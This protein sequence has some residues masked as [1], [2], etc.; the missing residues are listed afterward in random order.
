MEQNNNRKKKSKYVHLVVKNNGKEYGILKLN[1][2]V[3]KKVLT[4]AVAGVMIVSAG[5]FVKNE[6]EEN[7][8]ERE[9]EYWESVLEDY[10]PYEQTFEVPYTVQAGDTLDG[11]IATYEDD[12][13]ERYSIRDDIARENNLSS[14]SNIKAGQELT[15]TG[16]EAEDLAQFGYTVDYSLFDPMVKV[17]DMQ[18]FLSNQLHGLSVGDDRIEVY[19]SITERLAD[20]MGMYNDYENLDPETQAYISEY[21]LEQYEKL[22]ED[23]R[24]QFGIDF[25]DHLK[26]YPIPDS[27]LEENVTHRM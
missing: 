21:L 10:Q 7:K 20:L 18:E 24:E 26:C 16:L 23:Y 3:C 9:R 8:A 5:A 15:L 22:C 25:N 13:N 12:I 6:V 14:P 27:S 1:K 4:Y 19:A 2:I 17:T 11:I